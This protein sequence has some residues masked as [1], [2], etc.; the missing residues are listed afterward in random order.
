MTATDVIDK[1]IKIQSPRKVYIDYPGGDFIQMEKGW[2]SPNVYSWV[3]KN[4]EIYWS[5]Y[6]VQPTYMKHNSGDLLESGWGD[7]YTS[8]E[9]ITDQGSN[10][11]FGIDMPTA[12]LLKIPPVVKIG[13]LAGAGFI[14]YNQIKK[15]IK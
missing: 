6:G 9:G 7:G 15:H 4:G 12:Q 13:L 11:D 10:L 14:L 1:R 3:V 8:L 2:V 5:F